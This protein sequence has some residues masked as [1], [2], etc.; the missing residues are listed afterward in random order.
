MHEKW[1]VD[2]NL[3]YGF[4]TLLLG[5]LVLSVGFTTVWMLGL[6]GGFFISTFTASL[7]IE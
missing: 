1:P 3:Y 4:I 2:S 6:R 5:M 7:S